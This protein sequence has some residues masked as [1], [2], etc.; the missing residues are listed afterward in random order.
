MA[1][2]AVISHL[3]REGLGNNGKQ[4]VQDAKLVNGGSRVN[5]LS[6][7]TIA[8]GGQNADVQHGCKVLGAN[9]R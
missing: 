2:P 9:H 1:T 3:N 5:C 7:G 6:N 8:K 4:T